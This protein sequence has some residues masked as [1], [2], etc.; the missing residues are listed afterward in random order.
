MTLESYS[1]QVTRSFEKEL[2]K[3]VRRH[4]EVKGH[5][6]TVLDVLKKVPYNHS[7]NYPIAKL[8]NVAAGEGQYRIR[9]EHF[10]FR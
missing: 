5:Y 7:R 8:E 3:L 10:R 9:Y 4:G 1:V 6:N 2:L